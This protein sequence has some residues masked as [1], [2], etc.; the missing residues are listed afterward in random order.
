MGSK[1]RYDVSDSLEGQFQP[2]SRGKVLFNKLGITSPKEMDRA[3]ALALEKAFDKLL[4][5]YDK[6]HRFSAPDICAMHREWLGEIYSWAVYKGSSRP[7]EFHPQ[8]LS[9]PYV[10]LSIHT[11]LPDQT[12]FN[13]HSQCA[14][15]GRV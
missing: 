6:K 12:A 13:R 8:A 11:A 1:K 10:N 3:E 5:S 15:I 7:R 2:G 14:R 9:D 4:H